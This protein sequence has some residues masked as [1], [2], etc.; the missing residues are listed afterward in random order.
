MNYVISLKYVKRNSIKI[1]IDK[2]LRIGFSY[3]NKKCNYSNAY[4]LKC[5]KRI[6]KR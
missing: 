3:L 4:P 1:S 6:F 5:V 2:Y